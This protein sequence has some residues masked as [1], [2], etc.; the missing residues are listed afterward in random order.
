MKDPDCLFCKMVDGEISA[1]VV[2]RDDD[3][4]AFRDINPRAPTHILVIPTAHIGSVA[5]VAPEHEGLLGRLVVTA[6]ELAREEGIADSGFRLVVN[7]GAD[8]GQSVPHLHLHLLGG[9]AFDWP[10]G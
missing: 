2:H 1:D 4:F 6:K 8:A 9:R 10:P 7:A 3:V 5:D